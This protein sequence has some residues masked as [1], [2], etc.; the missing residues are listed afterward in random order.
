MVTRIKATILT[1]RTGYQHFAHVIFAQETL[2]GKNT[3]DTLSCLEIMDFTTLPCEGMIMSTHIKATILTERTG[4]QHFAHVI[5][6]QETL[7]GKNTQDTLSCL[8]IMDF[9]TGEP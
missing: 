8:E 2:N 6:A 1:E 7:N 3:Q 9:T 5:F 4:Y